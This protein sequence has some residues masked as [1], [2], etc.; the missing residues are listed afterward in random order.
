LNEPTAQA[1]WTTALGTGEIRTET[2][3]KPGP[4]EVQVRTLYSGISRGTERLVFHGM[5]PFSQYQAMRAPFQAG[6]FPAPV[7]YGYCNIGIVA[8]GPKPLKG[9]AV[10]C[11]YPHQSAY[12]VPA[13]AVVPLPPDVPPARAVLAA[14]METALNGLWDAPPP[15]GGRVAVIGAGVVGCLTAY[16]AAKIPGC[17]VQLIDIN[18]V[19]ATIA[20][21]LNVAFVPP[22]QAQGDCDLV[23]HTSGAPAGL[24]TAL[25]LA[26]FEATVLE[27]SWFGDQTVSLP[28]GEAFHSRRLTLRAS[29]V[30]Q[31]ATGQ[32]GRWSHRRRLE[33]ALALLADPLLENL[34]T[35]ES[36]FNRLPQTM[37]E[38]C[39]PNDD[40]LCH[41]I[42]YSENQ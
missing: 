13:T 38:L 36:P 8:A 32:R 33:T 18:P 4:D 3:P 24:V 35:G 34:I 25:S 22:E 2:L 40:S 11:L 39:Q 5:V 37:T 23:I 27:L 9:R 29:Q 16:L 21:K 28:L 17:Q 7:K 26:A 30:G 12:V 10:F 41:R 14:N 20:E 19:K 31:V 1:F 42:V 6:D 15:L